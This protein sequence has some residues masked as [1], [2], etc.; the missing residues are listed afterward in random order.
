M[1]A[2]NAAGASITSRKLRMRI[3][4]D[5]TTALDSRHH[6]PTA[7]TEK[8]AL[9][10]PIDFRAAETAALQALGNVAAVVAKSEH[11]AASA[12]AIVVILGRKQV[13]DGTVP[14][15]RS[16]HRLVSTVERNGEH[17]DS[18]RAQHAPD[19]A[20]AGRI[21]GHVLEYTGR[22]NHVEGAVVEREPLHVLAL[23]TVTPGARL[24]IV[25]KLRKGE[26]PHFAPE[27]LEQRPARGQ[28]VDGLV[29]ESGSQALQH[30]HER[31]RHGARRATHTTHPDFSSRQP[32]RQA[33]PA[34]RAAKTPQRYLAWPQQK[35]GGAQTLQDLE[36]WHRDRQLLFSSAFSMSSVARLTSRARTPAA[37]GRRRRAVP[38]SRGRRRWCTPRRRARFRRPTRTL[39]GRAPADCLRSPRRGFSRC[40]A[41]RDSTDAARTSRESC[42][43]RSAA[44]RPRPG[45]AC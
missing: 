32:Y 22:R 37:A 34:N 8:G 27:E 15:P 38:R 26:P 44:P 29:A 39:C 31:Q 12:N 14:H 13:F 3:C 11:M 24:D 25:E 4:H 36:G 2:A 42:S 35:D 18:A 16:L 21:V 23:D 19:L 28:L 10:A 43:R 45:A 41:V 30:A 20:K 33:R 5:P 6:D 40:G 1:L 17:E 7:L 9:E